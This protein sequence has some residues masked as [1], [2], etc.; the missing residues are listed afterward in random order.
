MDA[1]QVTNFRKF[2][3]HLQIR[4]QKG[5]LRPLILTPA[6]RLMMKAIESGKKPVV[7]KGYP[8]TRSSSTIF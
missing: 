1:E 4:D 6:Q 2:L 3:E 7:L 5:S 8:W